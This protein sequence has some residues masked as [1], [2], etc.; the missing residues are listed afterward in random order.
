M[1]DKTQTENDEEQSGLTVD[2]VPK[3]TM[4][5]RLAEKDR[6][7]AKEMQELQAQ[8]ETLKSQNQ[9]DSIADAAASNVVN[10]AQDV[11]PAQPP[12]IDAQPIPQDTPP[13]PTAQPAMPPQQQQQAQP[14]NQ[15][16][17]EVQNLIEQGKRAVVDKVK[18]RMEND[19]DYKKLMQQH[20]HRVPDDLDSFL[21]GQSHPDDLIAELVQDPDA[22]LNYHAAVVKTANGQ[23]IPDYVKRAEIL[24]SLSNKVA[25]NRHAKSVSDDSYSTQIQTKGVGAVNRDKDPSEMSA[26]E[27]QRYLRGK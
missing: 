6:K 26:V 11:Q 8:L 1:S 18:N 20:G 17:D 4:I 2:V 7:H 22:L 27:Y 13:V 19:E 25:A 21:I 16:L 9:G 3:S 10:A 23:S 24:N 5:N 14:E 15:G 12:A